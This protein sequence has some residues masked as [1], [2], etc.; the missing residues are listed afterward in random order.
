[1][2]V[3][4]GVGRR[5]ERVTKA[6]VYVSSSRTLGGRLIRLTGGGGIR[7]VSVDLRMRAL[8]EPSAD[9]VA[10]DDMVSFWGV[11]ESAKR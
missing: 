5:T 11:G 9:E 2:K 6:S 1:V 7:S 8:E 3:S 10:E 4:I